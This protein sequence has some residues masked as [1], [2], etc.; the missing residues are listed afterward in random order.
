MYNLFTHKNWKNYILF[1]LMIFGIFVTQEA[2]SQNDPA[3][4]SASTTDAETISLSFTSNANTDDILIAYSTTDDFDIPSDGISYSVNHTFTNGATVIYNGATGS[5]SHTLLTADQTYYYKAWSVDGSLNYSSGLTD[6]TKTAKY[7]ASYHIA[8]FDTTAVGVLNISFD[9]IDG[10]G[11]VSPDGYLIKGSTTNLAAIIDPVDGTTEAD[12]SLVANIAQGVEAYTFSSL[13]A[14]TTYYF[15]IYPYTN[16]GTLIDYKIDPVIPNKTITTLPTPATITLSDNTINE[17]SISSGVITVTLSNDQFVGSLNAANWT[18]NNLPSG[19]SKGILTRSSATEATIALTGTHTTDFDTDITTIEVVITGGELLLNTIGTSASSGVTII[20]NDDAETISISSDGSITEGAEDGE[21]ITVDLTGGT[22]ANTITIGNWVVT[23]LPEGV[24]K[25]S[26][27]RVSDVQA[28][29]VLSGNST[30]DYDSDIT[31]L[32]VSIPASEI[33]DHTG[34]NISDNTGVTFT[35]TDDVESIAISSDGLITEGTEN[36]EVIT[37]TLTNG[38]FPLSLTPANWTVTNFPI[39]VSVGDPVRTSSTTV[40]LTLSGNRSVDYDSDITNL[41]VSIT[42]DEVDDHT[43][44]ALSANTGVLFTAVVDVESIGLA[45]GNPPAT[46]GVEATMNDE[47]I[48]VTLAGGTFIN[49]QINT[50]NITISGDATTSGISLISATYVNATTVNLDIDWNG[51]DYD[52]NKTLTVNVAQVAFDEADAPLT[53]DIT[54]TATDEDASISISDDGILNEGSENT[55]IIT[56]TVDQDQFVV[57]LT[58]VNWAVNNLPDGV[59]AGNPVRTSSTTATITLSGTRTVDYDTD[60]TNLEVVVEG[61]EFVTHS[62]QATVSTGVTFIANDDAET[63]ALTYDGTITEGAEHGE[64]ITVT[65]TGGTYAD[66]LSGGNWS[67]TN[68]PT[69]VTIGGISRDNATQVT[70]TLTG[71]TSTDYDS[72]ITNLV[73]TAL[74]SEIDAQSSSTVSDGTGVVFT[75]LAES[76]AISHAGL[77]ESNLDGAAVSV[78]LTNE[79]FTDITLDEANFTLTNAPTGTTISSVVY[80]TSTTATINLAFDGT[81]FDNPITNFSITVDAVELTGSNDLVSNTLNI[82]AVDDGESVVLTW[83]TPPGTSGAEVTMDSEIINVTLTGGTFVSAGVT[84]GNITA[85]GTATTEG[86]VSIEAVAYVDATHINVSL[87]W[88]GTDYDTDKSLTIEVGTAAYTDAVAMISNSITLSATNEGTESISIAS[89]G[90]INEGSEDGEVI[91]I[92]VSNGSFANTLTPGNWTVTNLPIGVSAGSPVRTSPT[93]ATITL[94]GDRTVDYD[95]DKTDLT[96]TI[97]ADEVDDH[98]VTALSANTGITFIATNDVESISL[99]WAASPG[100]NGIE[101]TMDDEILEVSLAGGTFVSGQI[102]TTNITVAGDATSAAGISLFSATYVDANTV[103][104]ALDWDATDYDINK[105]LTVNVAQVAFDESDALLTDDIILTATVEQAAITISDDAI[106]EGSE[107]GELITVTLDQDI[108]V[109]GLNTSNWTVNNLPDGVIKGALVRTSDNTATIALS[110]TRNIDFDSDITNVEVV[111]LGAEFQTLSN[112]ATATTGVVI[113]AVADAETISIAYDGTITEGAEAS[114]DI[115]V[116]LTGG[117]FPFTLTAGNWSLTNAPTGVIVGN[118]V[119]DNATQATITLSGNRTVDYDA[120][121]SNLVIT[122][123]AAEIDDNGVGV[124][125]NGTG[126]IFTATDESLVIAHAGLIESNLDGA[127]ISL[128]LSDETFADGIL[129]ASNFTLNNAPAGVTINTVG[130]LTPSTVTVT[131]AFDGTDFDAA[132][133]NFNITIAAAELSGVGYVISNDLSISAVNDAESITI[134]WGVSPGTNGVEATM[135]DEIVRVT[136]TGGTFISGQI[137]TSNITVT[138]TATSAA[139]VS[140]AS[141]TYV[142]A[143]HID[144]ALDWNGT[145]YDTDKTLT[146][147]VAAAA[148]NDDNTSINGDINLPATDEGAESISISSGIINEGSEGGELITITVLNGSFA[149]SLNTTNWTVNNLPQ[150]V[151]KGTLTRTSS[152]TATIALSGDATIDYDADITNIEVVV[153]DAEIFDYSGGSLTDISGVTLTALNDAESITDAWGI[154]PNTGGAE[155]T[156]DAEIVQITLAGGTFISGQINLTNIT[157]DGDATT[158]AGVSI[159]S[160]FYVDATHINVSLAWNATDYDANKTLNIYV[161]GDAYDEGTTS[162][163][164]TITLT[165]TAEPILTISTTSLTHFGSVET[166][167]FSAE[168]SFTVAG[169][170]L[171]TDMV[172]TPPTGWEISTGTG[173]SFVASNPV[174][175]TPTT[176]TVSATAIYARF[177]PSITGAQTGNIT[178]ATTD[179]A[180]ENIAVEGYGTGA[181]AS[182]NVVVYEIADYNGNSARDYVELYNAGDATANLDGWILYER[183]T[184]STATRSIT[185]NATSQKNTSGSNYLV[186][187][188][189]EFAVIVYSDW[190]GL[191]TAYTIG[192]DVAIFSNNA[193]CNIDGDERYQ[194]D[195]PAKGIM[196]NFGDWDNAATFSLTADKA[197]ERTLPGADGELLSTWSSTSNKSYAYSPGS[198]NANPLPIDLMQFVAYTNEN[199]VVI[200]WTT[201]SEFNNDFF[202]LE[203]SYDG[204]HFEDFKIIEGMGST[205]QASFY[206]EIDSETNASVLYYRL[207]Q[208]DFDGKESYSDM[209]MVRMNESQELNINTIY[210]S[211]DDLVLEVMSSK[212]ERVQCNIF[213]MQGQL[214][215]SEKL[216]VSAELNTIR[217]N[218]PSTRLSQVYV[219]QLLSNSKNIQ[220]KVVK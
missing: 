23:G 192:D 24:T 35:A 217:L 8:G 25:S 211:N 159:E 7:E 92:T 209:I 210:F 62:N 208:T 163:S 6:N 136:L 177:A 181:G 122:A 71:N 139:G 166:G 201:A 146:I 56:V 77:I 20:A 50:T 118:I 190:S 49:A 178:I 156:M 57:S 158:T 129:S 119:R 15:Q 52:V 151:S 193:I 73:V 45:W 171:T 22:F 79:T 131:L 86:G 97:T 168:Q 102:N 110:G 185:L 165:A 115:I 103:R 138:G 149:V 11:L 197:Y 153:T 29:F 74:A 64:E 120:N 187:E 1:F 127:I 48:Q 219:V 38:T 124:S 216:S 135:D 214:L 27:V 173:G 5:Y 99:A 2:W 59:T 105:T 39:G 113:T 89:D 72:D 134:V 76:M 70:L 75:A 154:P 88:D 204:I 101:A 195:S 220:R 42:A 10:S 196:D 203:K 212:N 68:A 61:A 65:L 44:T 69:G 104:L 100:T 108:F 43:V 202:T 152:T 9:W 183:Y 161:D 130:Y 31:N 60:I 34:A 179:H 63:I 114:E 160:V 107:N 188:P 14:N 133:G 18:V 143:T 98:T 123:A 137:N 182:A 175:L 125:S 213:N 90:T 199:N 40:T 53:D 147:N 174:T 81:D 194:L 164:T 78:V 111:V 169:I 80:G 126:A 184:T 106:T 150:G 180:T 215:Y 155:A 189:G 191:K 93:T 207:K 162:L 32:D 54:L 26:L 116:T 46:N 170:N 144:V 4:F 96:V 67:V 37:V 13:T 47:I 16:S 87:A 172:I 145:D 30:Q 33:D 148:Y 28:T 128:S 142:D 84:T 109:A 94:S 66:P 121:I 55:E 117:T 132:I 19:I 112:T 82:S 36:G 218:T 157:A 206:K 141:A 17:G 85:S 200:E 41:T 51:T 186:L 198:A 83:G 167:S 58:P 205:S 3:S 176:G 140:I 95:S 12:G 21:I 91:T